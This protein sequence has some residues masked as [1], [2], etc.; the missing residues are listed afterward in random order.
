MINY[1]HVPAVSSFKV[2]DALAVREM[3]ML[4][5]GDRCNVLLLLLLMLFFYWF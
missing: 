2:L 4:I 5:V 1:Q 3:T